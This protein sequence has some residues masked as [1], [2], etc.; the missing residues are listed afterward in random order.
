MKR[1]LT[2]AALAQIAGPAVRGIHA[3]TIARRFVPV[4][5][6]KGRREHHYLNGHEILNGIWIRSGRRSGYF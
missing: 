3:Q 5:D 2:I 6:Q 1:L 4:G